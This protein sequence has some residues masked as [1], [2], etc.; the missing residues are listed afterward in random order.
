MLSQLRDYGDLRRTYLMT[1]GS[2]THPKSK[3]DFGGFNPSTP[4]GIKYKVLYN[5]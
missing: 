2:D 3:G 1:K 4:D 5:E